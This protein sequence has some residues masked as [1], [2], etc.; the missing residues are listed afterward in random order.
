MNQPADDIEMPLIVPTRVTQAKRVRTA[1]AKKAQI[2]TTQHALTQ[3][4]SE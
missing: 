4:T 3:P 1:V 2:L